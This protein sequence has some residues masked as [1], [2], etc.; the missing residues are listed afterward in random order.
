MVK[1]IRST[2]LV[3]FK[4]DITHSDSFRSKYSPNYDQIRN[5]L[6]IQNH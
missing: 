5:K 2:E 4:Q 6:S 3:N 1:N